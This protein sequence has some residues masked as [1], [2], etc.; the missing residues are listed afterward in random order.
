MNSLTLVYENIVGPGAELESRPV[1]IC[2]IE[3]MRT[4]SDT[5]A[6]GRRR[7]SDDTDNRFEPHRCPILQ[8]KRLS[9][10]ERE[11]YWDA[12]ALMRRSAGTK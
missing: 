4:G 7:F 8:E 10:L 1:I 2:G 3:Q 9:A 5:C 11:L 6:I 12:G